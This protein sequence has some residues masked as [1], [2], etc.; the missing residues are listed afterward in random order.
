MVGVKE[1]QSSTVIVISG[2]LTVLA[3]TRTYDESVPAWFGLVPRKSHEQPVRWFKWK[4]AMPIHTGAS[5]EEDGKVSVQSQPPRNSSY[6]LEAECASRFFDV[7]I[8][9]GNAFPFLRKACIQP[10]EKET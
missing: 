9:I 8:A 4:N 7:S 5:W 1:H 6:D 2:R 3:A 10:N